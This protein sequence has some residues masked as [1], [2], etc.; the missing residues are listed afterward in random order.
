[1]IGA[2][3]IGVSEAGAV[4]GAT[5]AGTA[6]AVLPEV[7]VDVTGTGDVSI[8]TGSLDCIEAVGASAWG[9]GEDEGS[10]GP[11]EVGVEVGG[12]VGLGA[13]TRE[14][15]EIKAC[16]VSGSDGT[17]SASERSCDDM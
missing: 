2:G 8:F 6:S 16:N 3:T 11:A 7:V 9:V 14:S 1:M 17:I 4:S 13:S 5:I 10:T 15:D 12:S